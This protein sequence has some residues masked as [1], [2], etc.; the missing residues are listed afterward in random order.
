FK[1][2]F[3]YHL[4]IQEDQ[5][6]VNEPYTGGYTTLEHGMGYREKLKRKGTNPNIRNII[7]IEMGRY[8]YSKPDGRV[9]HDRAEFIGEC[10]IRAMTDVN[11]A[12]NSG[13]ID[14]KLAV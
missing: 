5:I 12:I 10:K 2:R 1:Q 7:Q 13:K 14:L 8:L 4:G 9:D 6:A 11:R 3:A